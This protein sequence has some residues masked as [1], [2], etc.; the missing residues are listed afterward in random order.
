MDW[1]LRWFKQEN[2]SLVFPDALRKVKNILLI[3]PSDHPELEEEIH[4]FASGLYKIFT[5]AQVSTFDRATFRPADGNWFGLPNEGYLDNFRQAKFD[6]VIDLNM[7][8]DRLCTYIGALCGAPLRMNLVEGAYDHI[9]NFH[10]RIN[11]LQPDVRRLEK[12]LA[13]LQKLAESNKI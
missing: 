7:K 3:T 2:S 5:N 6:L 12:T 1:R 4:L 8:Q 9:Y 13:N 10:I 11:K